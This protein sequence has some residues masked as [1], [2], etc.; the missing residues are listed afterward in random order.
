MSE[1][2]E[3][4]LA[5]LAPDR[6]VDELNR[7]KRLYDAMGA[8]LGSEQLLLQEGRRA[9]E[10]KDPVTYEEW[11]HLI[12]NQQ[13]EDIEECERLS[14]QFVLIHLEL[15]LRGLLAEARFELKGDVRNR[16]AL[17]DRSRRQKRNQ[18][19]WIE[20]IRTQFAR[21]FNIDF[22]SSSE[23]ALVKQVVITRHAIIHP[24][25]ARDDKKSQ[26]K[27]QG[28]DGG[29]F[30]LTREGLI[31][32]IDRLHKFRDWLQE[33]VKARRGQLKGAGR[34]P[35]Q[36]GRGAGDSPNCVIFR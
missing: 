26:P 14:A 16:P 20:K 30:T 13:A 19:D 18:G 34:E 5:E 10:A 23:W 15:A 36:P 9:S 3:I 6:F 7:L 21:E 2:I 28:P 17:A 32:T 4:S 12:F 8:M 29:E 35:G 33:Q 24:E 31:L 1:P 25:G 11:E 22:V 27:A